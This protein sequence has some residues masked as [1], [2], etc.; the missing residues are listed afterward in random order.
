MRSAGLALLLPLAACASPPA[1]P[2]AR[3]AAQAYDDPAV[4]ELILKGVSNPYFQ[5]KSQGELAAARRRATED[6]L[7]RQGILPRSEGVAPAAAP[8]DTLFP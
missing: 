5:G 7:R 4:R 6:C 3:C 2:E 8:S 1:T